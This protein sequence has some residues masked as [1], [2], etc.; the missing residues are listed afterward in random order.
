ML[1]L[2]IW[3]MSSYH[4]SV[5][6]VELTCPGVAVAVWEGARSSSAPAVVVSCTAMQPQLRKGMACSKRTQTDSWQAAVR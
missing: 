3:D 4:S 6:T 5:T 1:L 2:E